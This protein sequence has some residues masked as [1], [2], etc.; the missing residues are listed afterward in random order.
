MFTAQ[1]HSRPGS[2]RGAR[3][4]HIAG[5]RLELSRLDNSARHFFSSGLALSTK[6][7]Y[8]SGQSSYLNFG[9]QVSIVL[10]PVSERALPLCVLLSRSENTSHKK[11]SATCQRSAISIFS[12][13][14]VTHSLLSSASCHTS[15]AAFNDLKDVLHN[16]SGCPLRQL[17]ST[18]SNGRGLSG[19]LDEML[20]CSGPRAALDFLFF[21]SGRIHGKVVSDL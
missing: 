12:R 17:N 15:F 21:T 11:S 8:Q 13:A 9:N 2:A 14:A 1:K 10:L 6:R 3:L 4:S 16:G 19:V 18:F 7:V 5:N 20:V